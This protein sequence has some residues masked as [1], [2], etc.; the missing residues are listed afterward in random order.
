MLVD[1]LSNPNANSLFKDSN[2]WLG[3]GKLK[4]QKPK[5]WIDGSTLDFDNWGENPPAEYEGLESCAVINFLDSST[6]KS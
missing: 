5:Q 6:R 4:G 2:Y 3:M 1:F